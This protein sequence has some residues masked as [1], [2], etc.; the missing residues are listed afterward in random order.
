MFQFHC[1]CMCLFDCDPTRQIRDFFLLRTLNC[2]GDVLQFTYSMEDM[3]FS[4]AAGRGAFIDVQ[5]TF[6]NLGLF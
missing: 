6:V 2:V 5:P 4:V 3:L 1:L